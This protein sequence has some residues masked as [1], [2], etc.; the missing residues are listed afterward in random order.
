M[1]RLVDLRVHTVALPLR[2]PVAFSWE[3]LQHGVY[4]FS[5]V[6]AVGDNGLSGFSAIE[7][8]LSYKYYVEGLVKVMLL[9]SGLERIPLD[10]VLEVGSWFASRLGPV[11][12]AMMDLAAKSLGKPLCTIIGGPVR[13]RLRI[14]A[15][16]GRLMGP[17][18]TVKAVERYREMGID[19][20]KIRFGRAR[21]EDDVE[22]MRR[23]WS[24]FKGSI[25]F[26]V[27]AN[28]AWRISPPFWSRKTALSVARELEK[29]EV[30][31]LEEPLFKDDL[32]GLRWL[33]SKVDV[34]IAGGELEHG[35]HRFRQI[36]ESGAYD[37]INADAIYSNGIRE[38]L[39]VANLA[40]S[41]G[42]TFLPHAWDP[43]LGYLANLHVASVLP[44]TL[45][46]YLETPL[47]PPWWFHTLF[48]V[49]S[50]SPEVRNGTVEVPNSPGLGFEPN[51]ELVEKYRMRP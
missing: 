45:T 47:D 37:I 17:E 28:Q 36:I 14:Y 40:N 42:L 1:V 31:W 20:V 38:V 46:P 26:A 23:L 6:E 8:G 24:E 48:S 27:D 9:G 7:L 15:S 35:V 41:H 13:S 22:V 30:E 5:I 10:R 50:G 21:V 11:E 16:T 43:A 2:E 33:R 19:M 51:M 29:Y 25:R 34:P 3:P 18:E 12:V 4:I 32:E 49:L 39:S 44:E